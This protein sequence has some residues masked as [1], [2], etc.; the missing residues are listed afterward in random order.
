M[1]FTPV[2]Y[3]V[4]I[5]TALG[6]AWAGLDAYGDYRANQVHLLYAQAANDTNADLAAF[7]GEDDARAVRVLTELRT[8]AAKAGEV[9]S[10]Q[11]PYT[12]EE[13]AAI[14]AIR[15]AAR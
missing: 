3:V 8:R 4:L 2:A 10:I 9:K 6:L 13:A 1:R 5:I 12:A 7:T 14:T 11:K 15:R